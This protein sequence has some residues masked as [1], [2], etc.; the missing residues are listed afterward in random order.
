M[1]N[2]HSCRLLQNGGCDIRLFHR[3]ILYHH[4]QTSVLDWWYWSI[5]RS[6][7]ILKG[8]IRSMA[9]VRTR[10]VLYRTLWQEG[11]RGAAHSARWP[12]GASVACRGFSQHMTQVRSSGASGFLFDTC[13]AGPASHTQC[14]PTAMLPLIQRVCAHIVQR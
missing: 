9:R 2:Q 6:M 3:C 4:P 5:E 10:T 11:F 14:F 12:Q 8:C 7:V 1:A 13:S